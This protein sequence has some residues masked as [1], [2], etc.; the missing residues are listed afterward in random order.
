MNN[1][2]EDKE[3]KYLIA[4]YISDTQEA[5][6]FC[7]SDTMESEYCSFNESLELV[8]DYM[9][10]LNRKLFGNNKL[11]LLGFSSVKLLNLALLSAKNY[12]KMILSGNLKVSED[13]ISL[14]KVDD[15]SCLL[16]EV[17]RLLRTHTL[18][19]SRKNKSYKVACSNNIDGFVYDLRKKCLYL[20]IQRDGN[21]VK[22]ADRK[23]ISYVEHFVDTK[24]IAQI[25]YRFAGLHNGH[26]VLVASEE[27]IQLTRKYDKNNV[28][29]YII[30]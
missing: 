21:F 1:L 18:E 9:K 26:I 28:I 8:P 7:D 10:R 20:N 2:D 4:N 30:L 3:M 27:R 23:S 25:V 29:S 17:R 11:T 14:F 15:T 19:Q 16:T 6:L 22:I 24:N 13:Y 12:T 5:L